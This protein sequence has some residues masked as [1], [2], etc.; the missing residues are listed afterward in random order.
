MHVNGIYSN[1]LTMAVYGD[2]VLD[3]LKAEICSSFF[4]KVLI[5]KIKSVI[6]VPLI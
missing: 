4:V 1:A 6:Y 5:L 2:G 3:G